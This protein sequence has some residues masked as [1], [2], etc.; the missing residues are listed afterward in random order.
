MATMKIAFYIALV[1]ALAYPLSL[2]W[3]DPDEAAALA[4]KMTLVIT[5]DGRVGVALPVAR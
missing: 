3:L 4:S 5:T 2:F 1:M